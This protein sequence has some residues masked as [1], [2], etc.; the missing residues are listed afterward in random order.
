M[1]ENYPVQFQVKQIAAS[2]GAK[3]KT[4]HHTLE[5][6]RRLSL[7]L[8]THTRA[9]DKDI[10]DWFES[11]NFGI[12]EHGFWTSLSQL[13]EF[14]TG[15]APS[16]AI[17][18]SWHPDQVQNP[19]ACFRMYCLRHMG[20]HLKEILTRLPH[21][22]WIYYQD[23]TNTSVQFP[24]IDQITAITP[25]FD[26][27]AYHTY[28]SVI[29]EN[30]PEKTIQWTCPSMDYAGEG[31]IISVSI[32]I[33]LPNQFIGLWSIDLPMK[34]L[35]QEALFDIYAKDQ[36]NFIVDAK[37]AL[38]A[39]P[40][41]KAGI[42]KEKGSVYKSHIHDLG[43]G[44]ARV[45]PQSL[46]DQES[47][48]FML[49]SREKNDLAVWFQAIPGIQWL[50][51]ATLPRQSMEDAVNLRIRHALDRVKSEDLSYRIKDG[52]D[53]D[54][55]RLVADGFNQMVSA[56]ELQEQ[57]RKQALKEKKKLEK[58]L[59]HSQGMEAMGTLASGIAHDFNNILFPI[60]GYSE[61]LFN[62]LP[63]ESR[64]F[65]MVEHIYQAAQR[66]RELIRQILTF[67][68][69]A[70][71][72]NQVVHLGSLFKEAL[73][74]LRASIP[75]NVEIHKH[76]RPD[77]PPVFGDPTKL[78][79]IVM[80][81]CTNAFHAVEKKGG[82]FEVTM[83]AVDISQESIPGLGHLAEGKYVRLT[84][85]DNGHGMDEKTMTHIF[86]P[87]FSTKAEKKGTGLGPAVIYGIVHKL[88][89]EITVYSEKD[90]GST[91]HVY[92]PGADRLDP[93]EKKPTPAMKGGTEKILLVDDEIGIAKMEK[94]SLE[95]YGYRVTAFTDSQKALDAFLND[96]QGFDLII[97]DMTMPKIT[98]DIL[99]DRIKT[100]RK[101]MP[102]I[103]CTGFSEKISS[104][105]YQDTKIDRFFMKP[106]SINDINRAIR[107][108][109]DGPDPT[110]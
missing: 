88:K 89:G 46:M 93:A 74:L 105:N 36:I 92:L 5:E 99:S 95:R 12:D 20:V 106:I 108:L 44:F 16:H 18:Y 45:D 61:L 72:K 100:L 94:Q 8:F 38:V 78:H 73:T 13:K 59:H 24:Y 102:I 27:S 28:Q 40:M 66:A 30:N 50:L 70:E 4:C 103:L 17:S 86:D 49:S 7:I 33:F 34:T 76:I 96:P 82:K 11:E 84:V 22:A 42:S 71:I 26:W 97:T 83:E 14:R 53:I 6:L 58:Q 3:I 31:V 48:H 101:D 60:L 54:Q 65:Q 21:A 9:E 98:G 35:Y 57:N 10:Q 52:S 81:L 64:E 51:F 41:A 79:Q 67:S 19:D 55:A 32:P 29:P 43:K 2:I 91:F 107:E 37:G 1:F 69:Q 109:V 87:Y 15:R 39:H 23:V 63:K 80:N 110:D 68:R 56:L 75:N 104:T 85:S 25:D 90:K 47:G 77:C 62:D